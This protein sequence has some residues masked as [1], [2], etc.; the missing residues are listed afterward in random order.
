MAKRPK[1]KMNSRVAGELLRSAEV[2]GDLSARARRIATTAGAGFEAHVEVGRT[3]TIA[4]VTAETDEA[5][6]AE[7]NDRAL[8]RALDAG[9]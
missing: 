7:A 3:R 6:A 8:T 9:R 5:R 2:A 4:R 1:V